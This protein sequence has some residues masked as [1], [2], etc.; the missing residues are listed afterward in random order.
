M[1]HGHGTIKRPA[2]LDLPYHIEER[3]P[4]QGRVLKVHAT[5]GH[6]VTEGADLLELVDD[7]RLVFVGQLGPDD[8]RLARLGV[9]LAVKVRGVAEEVFTTLAVV[10]A[11]ADAATRTL[12]IAA[13]VPNPQGDLRAGT[14]AVATARVP[15]GGVVPERDPR[16]PGRYY[17]CCESCDVVAAKPGDCPQCPMKLTERAVPAGRALAFACPIHADVE[18][19]REGP[20][21]RCG[22]ARVAKLVP[23]L[24]RHER[25]WGCFQA[26]ATELASRE[27]PCAVCGRAR[28]PIAIRPSLSVAASAVVASGRRTVVWRQVEPGVF[29]PREVKLGP[30]AGD[31]FEVVAGLAEGDRVAATGAFLLDAEAR[32]DPAAGTGW[33]GASKP[34]DR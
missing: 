28:V 4:L 2:A 29:E 22:L 19:P 32:L 12:R 15:L 8:A 33:F 24:G 17:G 3:A 18:E 11:R 7:R 30:R 23:S 14:P 5:V 31:R 9:P 1:A 20:C 16:P 6:H 21:G 10:D 26:H 25:R 13:E 34:E 27:G